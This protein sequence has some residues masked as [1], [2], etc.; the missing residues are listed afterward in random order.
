MKMCFYVL[1]LQSQTLPVAD[2]IPEQREY[3]GL[4]LGGPKATLEIQVWTI[5]RLASNTG[6]DVSFSG[7]I[8]LGHVAFY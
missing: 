3:H 2:S 6:N 4:A 8:I 5:T 1:R 7:H